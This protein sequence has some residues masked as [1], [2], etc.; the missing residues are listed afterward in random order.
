[1]ETINDRIEQLINAQFGGNKSSF[2]KKLGLERYNLSNYI[3]SKRRSKPSVDIVAKIVSLL[4]VDAYWLLT[5]E[6]EMLKPSTANE[7]SSVSTGDYSPVNLHGT[8]EVRQTTMAETSR[9]L[10]LLRAQLDE[11]ER[12]IQIQ[13]QLI[14]ELQKRK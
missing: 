3:S 8:M 11:K 5:G 13:Q 7:Q 2:A 9:E 14:S 6:G 4:D 1:M 12:T 10:E